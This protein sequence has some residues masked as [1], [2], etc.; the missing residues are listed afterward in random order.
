MIEILN[1]ASELRAIATEWDELALGFATPM[2]RPD[3][4]LAS[5]DAFCPPDRLQVVTVRRKGRLTALAPLVASQRRGAADLELL[6]AAQLYEPGVLL[7]SDPEALQ[8]L[9][10]GLL[11]LGRPLLLA[12]LAHGSPEVLALHQAWRKRA[13]IRLRSTPAYPWLDL[14][15]TWER[16]EAGLACNVR[17][18]LRRLRRRAEERGPVRYSRTCPEPIEAA[19]LLPELWRVEASGWKGREGTALL[20]CQPLRR[21]FETYAASAAGRGA[22]R[23]SLLRVGGAL[24][25]FQL[26]VEDAGRL[27]TLKIGHDESWSGCAPGILLSHLTIRDAFRQGLRAYEFGGVVEP[28]IQRWRPQLRSC[29]ALRAYPL[30]WRAVI[31]VG[32]E[33]S[34]IVSTALGAGA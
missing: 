14:E 27:W 31:G 15:G 24:V 23:V 18:D 5:A 30:A 3:W 29:I 12:R 21:F 10:E 34:G 11:A 13:F 1:D 4:G 7:Y 33:L 8:E 28:W 16:F 19:A 22:L 9:A 26:G 6:A 2:A 20:A 25:A 32:R 17:T